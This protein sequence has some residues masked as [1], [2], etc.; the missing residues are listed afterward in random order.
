[1]QEILTITILEQRLISI[2]AGLRELMSMANLIGKSN[3]QTEF[4]LVE[5]AAKYLGVHRQ[6]IYRYI[7]TGKLKAVKRTKRNYIA[8]ADLDAFMTD[9]LTSVEPGNVIFKGKG[10]RTNAN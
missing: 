9:G 7:S 3:D 8:K 1:M 2:E 6:T 4:I 10:G 5:D